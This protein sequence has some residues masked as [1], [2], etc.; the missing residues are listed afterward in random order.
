MSL[1][2]INWYPK[3]KEL[4][5]FAMIALTASVLIALMLLLIKGIR[6]QWAAN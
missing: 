2:E 5:N 6:I 1:I 3:H 4:R